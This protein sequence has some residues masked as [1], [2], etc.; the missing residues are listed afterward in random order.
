MRKPSPL[1]AT[2]SVFLAFNSMG[3]IIL[4]LVVGI[5]QAILCKYMIALTVFNTA[6]IGQFTLALR[7]RRTGL[8]IPFWRRS[9]SKGIP[10]LKFLCGVCRHGI[11]KKWRSRLWIVQSTK[12]EAFYFALSPQKWT[13]AKF[14]YI[15]ANN[16]RSQSNKWETGP[17]L[18]AVWFKKYKQPFQWR[19]GTPQQLWFWTRKLTFQVTY[20]IC[21][22]KDNGQHRCW[23]IVKTCFCTRNFSCGMSECS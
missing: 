17:P 3:M 11:S 21:I 2:E 13:T 8:E 19:Y 10:Q 23:V 4:L 9:I 12:A 6:S 1:P 15:Q 7:H 20:I 16:R 5:P 22:A 18:S 14:W